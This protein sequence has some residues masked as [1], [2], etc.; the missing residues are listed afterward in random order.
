M[1]EPKPLAFERATEIVARQLASFRLGLDVRDPYA[2]DEREFLCAGH[3][4]GALWAQDFLN[5][6]DEVWEMVESEDDLP[7]PP[8]RVQAV[9]E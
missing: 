7:A 8:S 3:I 4:V 1:S 2:Y 6:G 5:T 9:G